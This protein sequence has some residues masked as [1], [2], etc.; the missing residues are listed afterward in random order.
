MD[1]NIYLYFSTLQ[2][3]LGKKAREG[4]EIQEKGAGAQGLMNQGGELVY[5]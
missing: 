1:E 5:A 4:R 3:G 2:G